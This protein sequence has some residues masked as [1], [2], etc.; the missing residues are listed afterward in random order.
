MRDAAAGDQRI[1]D[2]LFCYETRLFATTVA[3][4]T[5]RYAVAEKTS[6]AAVWHSIILPQRDGLW[7]IA[8]VG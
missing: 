4:L 8:I 6:A 3:P 7:Y 1:V 5:G 2:G